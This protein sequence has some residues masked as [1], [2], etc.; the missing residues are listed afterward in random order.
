MVGNENPKTKID[1]PDQFNKSR[2]DHVFIEQLEEIHRPTNERMYGN[3]R[4]KRMIA[5][6]NSVFSR[7]VIMRK[8]KNPTNLLTVKADKLFTS[9]DLPGLGFKYKQLT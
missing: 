5:K 4:F 3:K 1:Q 6:M 8:I 7:L 9:S 2:L